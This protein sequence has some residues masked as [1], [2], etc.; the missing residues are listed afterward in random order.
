M[1]YVFEATEQPYDSENRLQY[2][3]RD[4]HVGMDVIIRCIDGVFYA[5]SFD[6]VSKLQKVDKEFEKL[7][8]IDKLKEFKDRL[9]KGEDA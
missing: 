1:K 9:K 4:G 8:N 3:N 6:L 2:R 7:A 5:G